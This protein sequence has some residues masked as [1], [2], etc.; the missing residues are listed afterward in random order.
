MGYRMDGEG[1]AVGGGHRLVVQDLGLQVAAETCRLVG[2]LP[3][4]LRSQQDQAVRASARIPLAIA[5]GA[6]RQGRD[7][8]RR[9]RPATAF[10]HKTDP[11][12][13]CPLTPSCAKTKPS[14]QYIASGPSRSPSV[15]VVEPTKH[16]QG[17]LSILTTRSGGLESSPKGL[18]EKGDQEDDELVY[19]GDLWLNAVTV[20]SG[21]DT[22][23]ARHGSLGRE[24]QVPDFAGRQSSD[25]GQPAHVT[26]RMKSTKTHLWDVAYVDFCAETQGPCHGQPS[27]RHPST[28]RTAGG[29]C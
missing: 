24:K 19:C 6:G 13:F 20:S 12:P 9:V 18:E 17:D 25:E 23:P 16:R 22:E 1:V 10:W 5:E 8:S 7:W 2:A 28:L 4:H 3:N 26:D 29:I 21:T 27:P 15:V 11:D 14:P